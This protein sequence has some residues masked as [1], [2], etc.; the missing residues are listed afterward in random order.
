MSELKQQLLLL[1]MADLPINTTNTL[2]LHQFITASSAHFDHVRQ[3]RPNS[4]TLD[5]LLGFMTL[6][7]QKGQQQWSHQRATSTKM[8]AVF[9]D[10]IGDDYAANFTHQD[11]EYL[12]VLTHLWLMVQGAAGI[13]Y[14]YS[15]EQAKIQ[16]FALVS[17]ENTVAPTQINT[18][19]ESLRCEFM[20]SY[21]LGKNHNRVSFSTRIKQWFKKV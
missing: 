21:Y 10:T 4:S 19:V 13:D 3:Q 15:N 18:H 1:G 8:K 16:S 17:H 12:L 20:Q 9:S 11:L 5:L 7:H 6:H 14:S 2:Q